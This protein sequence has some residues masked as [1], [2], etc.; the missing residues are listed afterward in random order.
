MLPVTK[1]AINCNW[2][3]ATALPRDQGELLHEVVEHCVALKGRKG[4]R[5]GEADARKGSGSAERRRSP[6]ARGPTRRARRRA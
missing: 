4:Q 2:R 5:D 3:S 1:G 6:R